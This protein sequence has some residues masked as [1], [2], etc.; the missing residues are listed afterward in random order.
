MCTTRIHDNGREK[1]RTCL[2][3]LNVCYVNIELRNTQYTYV[4]FYFVLTSYFIKFLSTQ[5]VN[6]R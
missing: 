3:I 4:T 5:T 1:D 6:E 2:L